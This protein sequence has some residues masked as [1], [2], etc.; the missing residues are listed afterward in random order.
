MMTRRLGTFVCTLRRGTRWVRLRP[1]D[2]RRAVVLSGNV[3]R[4]GD[5]VELP[6]GADWDAARRPRPDGESALSPLDLAWT[7]EAATRSWFLDPRP[8]EGASPPPAPPSEEEFLAREVS[9]LLEEEIPEPRM[10][11]SR[12]VHCA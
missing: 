12:N 10:L 6:P 7:Y 9:T 1:V 3:L 2:G 8:P 11:P 5:G 4:R